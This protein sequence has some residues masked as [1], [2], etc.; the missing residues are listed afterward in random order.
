MVC[1]KASIRMDDDIAAKDGWYITLEAI[2]D[3]R[4]HAFGK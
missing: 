2:K 4:L 1:G 3:A